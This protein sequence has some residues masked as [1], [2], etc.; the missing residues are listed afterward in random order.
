MATKLTES[1]L[2][3]IIKEEAGRLQE[4]Y[5][6]PSHRRLEELIDEALQMAHSSGKTKVAEHLLAAI[7][8]LRYS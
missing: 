6:D 3:K 1:R 2:R 7:S 8:V 4:F 5:S